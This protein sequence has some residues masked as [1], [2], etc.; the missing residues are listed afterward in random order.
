MVPLG[1][2]I[3]ALP[4][5]VWD[6]TVDPPRWPRYSPSDHSVLEGT[7]PVLLVAQTQGDIGSLEFMLLGN[8]SQH[9]LENG[10]WCLGTA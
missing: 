8:C 5:W 1:A 6:D 4:S 7:P 9:C 2:L 10:P 3:E